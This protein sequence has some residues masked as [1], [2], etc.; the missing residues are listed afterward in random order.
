M[1]FVLCNSKNLCKL[2][3]YAKIMHVQ[4][5]DSAEFLFF[6]YKWDQCD[7]QT[8]TR[9]KTVSVHLNMNRNRSH[10]YSCLVAN[11]SVIKDLG[12]SWCGGICVVCGHKDRSVGWSFSRSFETDDKKKP[13][14]TAV[15]EIVCHKIGRG[16]VFMWKKSKEINLWCSTWIY[17]IS[18]DVIFHINLVNGMLSVC[19]LCSV[20][21]I[22]FSS[23]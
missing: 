20:P 2:K 6:S 16:A 21:S 11:R 14:I 7:K 22:R 1:H 5:F 13:T 8:T 15:R 4:G 10:T 19:M 17:G 18:Q 12:Q 3:T 9:K 23:V